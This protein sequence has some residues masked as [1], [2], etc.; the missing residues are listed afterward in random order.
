MTADAGERAL[1]ARHAS[2]E[3][4]VAL[5]RGQQE[6]KA[7]VVAPAAA[8]RAQN[9]LLVLMAPSFNWARPG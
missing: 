3:E 2:A 7:D 6:R 4:L 5:L 1:S 8:I 9:G